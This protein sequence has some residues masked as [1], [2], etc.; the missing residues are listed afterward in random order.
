MKKSLLAAALSAAGIM[1]AATAA[2]AH[3]GTGNADPCDSAA[4]QRVHE[5]NPGMQEMHERMH[6][7][8]SGMMPGMQQMHGRR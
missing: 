5:G 7:E 1:I 4:M 8:K 3:S 2:Q 6:S